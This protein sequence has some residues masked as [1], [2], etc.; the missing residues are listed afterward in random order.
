MQFNKFDESSKE[1][2]ETLFEA[3]REILTQNPADAK[4]MAGK[5]DIDPKSL[6]FR[7]LMQEKLKDYKN[8]PEI[9]KALE[10]SG[11]NIDEWLNYSETRYFNLESDGSHLAF[12]RSDSNSH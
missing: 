2:I 1:N 7:Q 8:N 5:P 11:V 12:F 9:L 4:A 3:K 6:E 10:E